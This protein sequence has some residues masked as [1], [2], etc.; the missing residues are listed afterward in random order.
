MTRTERHDELKQIRTA[1]GGGNRVF[2]IYNAGKSDD[3]GILAHASF[4]GGMIDQILRREFPDGTTDRRRVEV[5]DFVRTADGAAG[6]L[7]TID[8]AYCNGYVRLC[9]D[10]PGAGMRLVKIASLEIVDCGPS[11]TRSNWTRL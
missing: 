10:K 6:E 2:V 1:R 4:V 5:G 11:A 8:D 9:D 3:D 7:A